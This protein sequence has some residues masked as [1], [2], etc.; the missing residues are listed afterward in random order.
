MQHTKKSLFCDHPQHKKRK[1][2]ERTE[3]SKLKFRLQ[4][5]RQSC[6]RT[7][8]STGAQC[9][10]LVIFL[11]TFAAQAASANGVIETRNLWP[12][13]SCNRAAYAERRNELGFLELDDYLGFVCDLFVIA[14]SITQPELWPRFRQRNRIVIKCSLFIEISLKFAA[15]KKQ[16]ELW[17]TDYIVLKLM[18]KLS[19]K[20]SPLFSWKKNKI[21]VEHF[22]RCFLLTLIN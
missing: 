4:R 20:L 15:G 5:A 1:L 6:A 8:N 11:Q 13:T 18:L 14:L 21:S 3:S 2:Y 7:K 19:R 9:S 17:K 22:P 12:R 16:L 10:D